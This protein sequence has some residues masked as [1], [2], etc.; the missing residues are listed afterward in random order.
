MI[1]HLH[2]G[3]IHGFEFDWDADAV[4][5]RLSNKPYAY[6]KDLDA[7]RRIDYAEDGSPIGV[8][9]TC[10]REGVTLRDLPHEDEIRD[11]L[12]RFQTT[13]SG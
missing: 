12:N 4:Y 7:E 5:F 3:A 11:I 8:E 9:I 1:T 6:G 10:V 13:V 2:S